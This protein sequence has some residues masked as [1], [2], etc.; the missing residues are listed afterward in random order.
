MA[1]FIK[2]PAIKYDGVDY[3]KSESAGYKTI[4]LSTDKIIY[5]R[6][7]ET[8]IG[9]TASQT[10]TGDKITVT[11]HGLSVD[12]AIYFTVE[13]EPT[14]ILADR[15]YYV[16]AV[17]DANTISVADAQ[18]DG[19]AQAIAGNDTVAADVFKIEAEVIYADTCTNTRPIELLLKRGVIRQDHA[20]NTISA[21]S[22]QLLPVHINTKNGVDYSGTDLNL[23]INT[24]RV[25]LSYESGS[26]DDWT[27]FYDTS[28][29]NN[30]GFDSPFINILEVETSLDSASN[31]VKFINHIGALGSNAPLD[32]ETLTVNG[33]VVNFP[34]Q[35][36][37]G[38]LRND[39]VVNAYE[40][41]SKVY[42]KMKGMGKN[43]FDELVLGNTL[44]E[45]IS[46]SMEDH[47]VS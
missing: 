23:V 19:T 39:S 17:H 36:A 10:A 42:I 28:K 8:K 38:F 24:D 31:K 47:V 25:I 44:D 45:V 22:S 43:S 2:V 16:Q 37:S 3:S 35:T 26:A 11:G 30:A 7:I 40:A 32:F 15:V 6:D 4:G 13:I 12:D 20:G 1:N 21:L 33:N 9:S 29:T 34:D 5:A 18:G 41:S 14:N 46:T 27:V